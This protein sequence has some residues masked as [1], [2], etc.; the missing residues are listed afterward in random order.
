[1]LTDKELAEIKAR[2]D[3][4]SP[5]PYEYSCFQT[6]VPALLETIEELKKMVLISTTTLEEIEL[7]KPCEHLNRRTVDA[8]NRNVKEFIGRLK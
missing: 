4:V 8:F 3:K 6:D 7:C 5:G 1:M 2:A